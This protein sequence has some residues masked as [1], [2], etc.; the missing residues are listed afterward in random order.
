MN[1]QPTA[2]ARRFEDGG[3]WRVFARD[4]RVW[5]VDLTRL[6]TKAFGEEYQRYNRERG[7]AHHPEHLEATA[8]PSGAV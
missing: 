1:A 7:R 2:S 6:N 8:R 5:W 4:V 3:F